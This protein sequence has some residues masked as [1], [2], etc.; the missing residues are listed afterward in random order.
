MNVIVV[1]STPNEHIRKIVEKYELP[2]YINTGEGGIAQDWN[3][4][5][6][7]A[8]S[9]VV[10][11]AHQDDIYEPDFAK[12][13]LENINK[14]DKPLIAFTDYGELRENERVTKN[15][16]LE[17][18]RVMLL[19][20]RI[21]VLQRSIFVRRRILS[22][23]SPICCPSVTY[24]KENLPETVFE[25]GYRGGVDWQ[26]WEKLSKLKGAFVYCTDIL[27]Y[28]RIHED[29]ETSS[30]IADS[31]RTKEDFEMFCKF[32]PKW[33]ARILEHFYKKSENS[34]EIN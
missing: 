10:T 18:K 26:A 29:S 11:I 16:L 20:M 33:I 9:R 30:I 12:N 7:M 25:V 34:N 15:R 13:I 17:V 3:Y 2:Y 27:M 19:P 22:F 24:V 8:D 31:N 4:G 23:G 21:R 14:H 5:M 1:T 28:H 32:W 6:K